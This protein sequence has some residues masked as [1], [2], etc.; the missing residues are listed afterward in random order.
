MDLQNLRKTYQSIMG[1]AE[2]QTQLPENP[3]LQ[4]SKAMFEVAMSKQ[5]VETPN[6][7]AF[8]GVPLP[9]QQPQERPPVEYSTNYTER[10]QNASQQGPPVI[11]HFRSKKSIETLKS[12]AK[13]KTI[14]DFKYLELIG[15]TGKA[16]F[17][18]A[19]VS[20][21]V[22]SLIIRLDQGDP[23][24]NED[25][26]KIAKKAKKAIAHRNKIQNI[27]FQPLEDVELRE[28]YQILMFDEMSEQNEM[29]TLKLQTT[30]DLFRTMIFMMGVSIAEVSGS[31]ISD[32]FGDI[33]DI[34]LKK[35]GL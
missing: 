30:S 9:H 34:G 23:M 14:I 33:V 3:F 1:S 10:I 22:Q 5:A 20:D 29:G 2:P 11:E 31:P 16:I 8:F 21:T 6:Q 12:A 13:H 15:K 7:N 17:G 32:K 18:R 27:K 25:E 28:L 26:I 4:A 35:V 24:L 19:S